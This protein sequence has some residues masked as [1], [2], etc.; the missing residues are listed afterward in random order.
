MLPFN[1]H[2]HQHHNRLFLAD[3]GKCERTRCLHCSKRCWR[4]S[5]VFHITILTIVTLTIVILTIVI[6]AIVILAIVILTIVILA[7]VFII[8]AFQGDSDLVQLLAMVHTARINSAGN[9]AI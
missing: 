5:S 3:L 7:I 6:L 4:S 8:M 9:N 2:H 1:C